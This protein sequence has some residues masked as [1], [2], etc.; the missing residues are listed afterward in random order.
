MELRNGEVDQN[1]PGDVLRSVRIANLGNPL[2]AGGQPSQA[3]A[4]D[5][6]VK[7]M[8][9]EVQILDAGLGYIRP[10]ERELNNLLSGERVLIFGLAGCYRD[11]RVGLRRYADLAEKIVGDV[12]S[13]VWVVVIHNPFVVGS[14]GWQLGKSSRLRLM[15]DAGGQ[16]TTAVGLFDERRWLDLPSGAMAYA[17]LV[18]DG[19]VEK[20]LVQGSSQTWSWETIENWVGSE[21]CCHGVSVR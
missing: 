14:W 7:G 13:E 15:S 12:V 2:A 20:L 11:Y 19:V 5:N 4:G 1:L 10:V 18:D 6:L 17:L 21:G 3:A 9:T 16:W 8:L